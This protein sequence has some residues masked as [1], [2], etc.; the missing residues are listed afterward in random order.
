M[1]KID[2]EYL[3]AQFKIVTLKDISTQEEKL[4]RQANAI[5][6]LDLYSGIF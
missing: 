6:I 4:V 1:D 2:A 5:N 3:E